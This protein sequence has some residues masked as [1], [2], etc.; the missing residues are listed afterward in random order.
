M[1]KILALISILSLAAPA[2]AAHPA[3]Q[4]SQTPR[5]NCCPTDIPSVRWG[6]YVM[7]P[8]IAMQMRVH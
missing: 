8:C 5:A 4:A 7:V 2:L 6:A 1:K 3:Q